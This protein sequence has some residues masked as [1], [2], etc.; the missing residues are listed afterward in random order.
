MLVRVVHFLRKLKSRTLTYLELQLFLTLCS[1]PLL[2]A[3]G[4]PHAPAG[5]VG[6]LL[7]MPILSLFLALSSLIFFC[8]L[9]SIPSTL[10]IY[11][12]EQIAHAWTFLLSLSSRSW[13]YT[14]AHPS[15][16]ITLLLFI[17]ACFAMHLRTLSHTKRIG[18]F[19][20]LYLIGGFLL[21]HYPR[22]RIL[23]IPYEQKEVIVAQSSW[24]TVLIDPGVF[25]RRL[26]TPQWVRYTLVPYLIT[27]GIRQLEG[28]IVQKP[29]CMVFKTLTACIE[30]FPVRTLYI[31]PWQGN[32]S[33]ICWSAWETLL[34]TAHKYHTKIVIVTSPIWIV[35]GSSCLQIQVAQKY[36]TKNKLRYRELILEPLP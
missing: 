35:C 7:F 6:N 19:G 12:L 14:S 30:K 26:S 5:I 18:M 2:C 29:S 13:L 9:V 17:I 25:G 15:L 36:M 4:I 3:W 10:C 11:L 23:R 22:E 32:C 20:V 27:H 28:I 1:W 21:P 31:P 34:W 16:G 33:N 24:E 8:E